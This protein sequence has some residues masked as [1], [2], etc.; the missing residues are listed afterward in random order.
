M[1]FPQDAADD[2]LII[3]VQ[4]CYTLLEL[5]WRHLWESERPQSL[6]NDTV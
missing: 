1:G 3:R 2:I 5:F 6:R 4:V